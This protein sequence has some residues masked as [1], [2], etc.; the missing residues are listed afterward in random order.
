MCNFSNRNVVHANKKLF[1]EKEK[2]AITPPPRKWTYL[3]CGNFWPRTLDLLWPK[4]IPST[5]RRNKSSK[6]TDDT[7]C[8]SHVAEHVTLRVS[9]LSLLLGIK[10][11]EEASS[12]E[13]NAQIVQMLISAGADVNK[14]T[15]SLP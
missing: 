3:P 6:A 9:A 5:T 11:N 14:N 15:Q 12:C 7:A 2:M 13:I 10:S 4:A 1:P 8:L